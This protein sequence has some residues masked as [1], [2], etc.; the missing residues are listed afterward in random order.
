MPIPNQSQSAP[1]QS[2]R[3]IAYRRLCEAIFDG[4]LLPGEPL[5]DSELSTWLGISRTPLREA[6]HDLIRVG[7]VQV[8]PQ[9]HCRVVN[10][11]PPAKP[12]VAYTL[13]ALLSALIPTALP[14]H[15]TGDHTRLLD[16][17]H[18]LVDAAVAHN[19]AACNRALRHLA[20]RLAGASSNPV[21]T[22]GIGPLLPGLAYRL[23][24][25]AVTP[26][27]WE[28]RKRSTRALRA[29]LGEHNPTSTT[30]AL[31]RLLATYSAANVEIQR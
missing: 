22:D 19:T 14:P 17:A 8:C 10:D 12:Q 3:S 21:L 13:S 15:N 23:T 30:H 11:E 4:T 26:P 31:S 25:D 2:A 28:E 18:D 27:V 24:I 20:E 9:R 5:R 1:R 16:A 29:A 7:L 6:I